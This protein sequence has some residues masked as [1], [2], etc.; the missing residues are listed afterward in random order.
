MSYTTPLQQLNGKSDGLDAQAQHKQNR[1]E[2]K[3]INRNF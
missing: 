3:Y 2:N 1:M